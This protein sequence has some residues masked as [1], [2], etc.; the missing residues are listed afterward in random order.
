MQAHEI[1][2]AYLGKFLK[3]PFRG[4]LIVMAFTFVLAV[5]SSLALYHLVSPSISSRGASVKSAQ[6]FVSRENPT[7]SHD[8]LKTIINRNIFNKTGEIPKDEMTKAEK[9]A[10]QREELIKSELPLRLV[11]VIYGG[12][13]LDGIAMIEN[14]ESKK[15]NSFLVGENVIRDAI[16]AEVQENRAILLVTDH[17]EYIEVA[18]I[19]ILRSK[20]AKKPG[21]LA[22]PAASLL[23][24][25]KFAEEGFERD[26]NSITMS[27]DY[28]QKLLTSDFSKVLQDSKAEPFYEGGELA[29]FRLT[30]IRADSVYEKGGLQNDDI[31]KEING[32]S[33]VDT[34]QAIKLL[35]SLR[36]E[37]DI[38]VGINRGGK[39]VNVHIQVK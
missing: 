28:R 3:L 18:D 27:A 31:V 8:A 20:R 35:N 15:T 4:I 37:N 7:L 19:P 10:S 25:G 17:K 2:L 13:P 39:K 1:L 16:L 6:I 12:S 32:V 5:C 11:G 36:G 9:S 33:L 38:E 14:T 22:G 23:P 21:K 29:G 30:R 24:S 26:G 34:G